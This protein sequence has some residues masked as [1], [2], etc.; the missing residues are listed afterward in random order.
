M[1]TDQYATPVVAGNYMST[2]ITCGRQMMSSDKRCRLCTDCYVPRKVVAPL[3]AEQRLAAVLREHWLTGTE[4]NEQN[5]TNV[6]TCYCSKWRSRV[7]YS[8]VAAV[9]RW[10]EHVLAHLQDDVTRE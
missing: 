10:I 7:E 9:E 5:G 8:P 2:C 1:T 4:C 3:T 6:A